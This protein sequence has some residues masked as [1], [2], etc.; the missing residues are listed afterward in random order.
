MTPMTSCPPPLTSKSAELSR[1]EQARALC[2]RLL[3][4]RARTRAELAGQLTKRGYP[5]D[6]SANGARPA[7]RRRPG[8]RRRLRRAVGA[9]APGERRKRQARLGRRA[10]HQGRRQRGDQPPRSP[11]STQAPSGRAPSNWSATNCAAN[12][13]PTTTPRWPG[14]WSACWRA[15]ATARPWRSTSSRS[16]WPTNASAGRSRRQLESCAAWI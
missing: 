15:A 3:T 4:A 8:R 14:G 5:D 6:V 11:I 9:V 2:L 7:G 13:S 16:H 12:G 10:P 1:E